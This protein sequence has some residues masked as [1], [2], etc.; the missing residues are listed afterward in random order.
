MLKSRVSSTALQKAASS[1]T[2]SISASRSLQSI[3][4]H[5]KWPISVTFSLVAME[6]LLLLFYPLF[7]GFAIDAI[8]KGQWWQA[9]SYAL[10][11]LSFWLIGALRRSVDTYVYTRIYAKLAVPVIQMQRQ[12]NT[13]PS[14]MVARVSLS[15]E[16]VDFFEKHIPVL[17][18]S[19]LSIVGSALMLTIIEFWVG[20]AC[21]VVM[22]V[23]ALLLPTFSTRNQ[24]LHQ[25]LNDRLEQDVNVITVGTPR[26]LR[27]HYR[28]LGLIRVRIS[29]REALAYLAIGCC[30]ALL[31]L[32]AISLLIAQS[33]ISAGHVYAVMTY[34]WTF[35]SSLDEGPGLADQY[36][37]LRD[38]GRRVGTSAH[39]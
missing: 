34:L 9:S 18:T 21:L 14:S 23:F 10:V 12:S 7:A 28:L 19:L 26:Y 15:R 11:V 30:A 33:Q 38:I 36:A 24:R 2:A 1:P 6:N 27:Q 31:F 29:N 16:F 37:R 22:L 32:L 20:M 39:A 8:V 35:V 17:A 13:E 5:H 3:A 25:R 4:R